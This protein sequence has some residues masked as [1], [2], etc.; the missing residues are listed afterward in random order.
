[1]GGREVFFFSERTSETVPQSNNATENNESAASKSAKSGGG[2]SCPSG[3]TEQEVTKELANA[4]PQD[5]ASILDQRQRQA[6]YEDRRSNGGVSRARAPA[7]E[8]TK[9]TASLLQ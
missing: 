1:M 7:S 3:V 6:K 9:S 5:T 4:L 8:L 2:P